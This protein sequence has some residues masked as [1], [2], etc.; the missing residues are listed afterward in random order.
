MRRNWSLVIGVGASLWLGAFPAVVAQP[1][2]TVH[3]GSAVIMVRYESPELS[4]QRRAAIVV[5]G[6]FACPSGHPHEGGECVDLVWWVNERGYL[7]DGT[8]DPENIDPTLSDWRKAVWHDSTGKE[9][10][11]WH[12][13]G[14][15]EGED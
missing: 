6:P 1:G 4:G 7:Y 2:P 12:V 8:G 3:L 5:D 11:S 15:A 10:R 13:W 9:P 14:E